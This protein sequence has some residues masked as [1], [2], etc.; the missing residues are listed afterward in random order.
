MIAGTCDREYPPD[1]EPRSGH[2][3]ACW[4]YR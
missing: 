4:L 3:T 2:G 1:L